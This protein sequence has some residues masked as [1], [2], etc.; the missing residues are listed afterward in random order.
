MLFFYAGGS[1]SQRQYLVDTIYFRRRQERFKPVW[2]LETESFTLED[3][4]VDVDRR[5]DSA[6]KTVSDLKTPFEQVKLDLQ[7][8]QSRQDALNREIAEL[9]NNGNG[10]SKKKKEL[11]A[12]KKAEIEQVKQQVDAVRDEMIVLENQ[13]DDALGE[14]AR[15]EEDRDERQEKLTQIQGDIRKTRATVEEEARD[16][17]NSFIPE[18]EEYGPSFYIE[19]ATVVVIIFTVLSLAIFGVLGG[20][21]TST[22]L[23]A[24]AGYVLGK[25]TKSPTR[26]PKNDP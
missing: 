25:A 23:A 17:A 13:F 26:P 19:L 12:D 4:I 15:L 24:I 22:I 10:R 14:V 6:R 2:E 5:L 7:D 8:I 3:E 20:Q 11:L 21:E 18:R 9:E 16:F 1:K